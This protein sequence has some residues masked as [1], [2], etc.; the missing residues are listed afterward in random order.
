MDDEEARTIGRRVRQIRY[1]RRKSLRVVAGLA[2]MSANMLFRIEKGQRALDSRSEIAAL[3][4]ALGVAPSELIRMPELPELLPGNGEGEAVKAVRRALQAVSR[5]RLDGQVLPVEVLGTRVAGLVEAQGQE[6]NHEQVG[7]DLPAVIQDLH[8]T[9]AA[10]RDV[11]E[12]LDL[13]VLLHARGSHP[14][15]KVMGAPVDLRSQATLLARQAAEH[16]DEPTAVGLAVWADALV[17]LAEGDFDLARDALGLVTVPTSTSK[18]MQLAGMLALCESLVAAADKRP[19]DTEAALE[20]AADLAAHTG[21]GNAYNLGFGPLNVGLWRM[22][23]VLE[24]GDHE[25]TATIAEG[26]N[27]QQHPHGE[28]R[29]AYWINY[30][31]AVARLRGRQNDAVFAFRRAEQISPLH[32]LRNPFARDVL[33]ELISQTKRDAAGIELRGMAYRAGLPVQAVR[34]MRYR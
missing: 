34:V 10:G 23:A 25:R 15:L 27:P 3:A 20:Y 17:M 22:S 11:A 30:G 29:A 1:A 24:G 5:N 28:R 33:A 16:R 6:C 18:G 13:V 32:M 21:E 9:M 12:L 31:R 2:G 26:L 19:Q 4:N 14:W 7:R 8:T